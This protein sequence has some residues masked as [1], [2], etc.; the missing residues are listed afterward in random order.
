[1]IKTYKITYQENNKKKSLLINTENIKNE[2]LPL[3]VLNIKEVSIKKSINFFSKKKQISNKDLNL[4]FY[5]LNIMVQ[6]NI[7][8][9]EALDILIKNRK[10]EVLK[11]FLLDMKN[12]F[13]NLKPIT[14]ALEKYEVD[15]IVFSFL[16][17]CQSRGNIKLNIKAL[18]ILLHENARIKNDFKKAIRYPITLLISFFLSLN[19]IFYFVIP[20]F[21]SIFS[22][23]I[24]A[25][26]LSTKVLFFVHDVYS[27]Y[28][29]YILI[30]LVI[31]S[32]SL[33]I[34][35]KNNEKMQ[36]YFD[37]FIVKKL[38]LFKDIYLSSQSYKLFLILDIMHKS[39]Y[40]FHKALISSKV[41]LKNKY[42]LD[43][44]TLIENLLENG[45]TINYSFSEALIFDD[46]VL[47]L[48]NTAEVSN[49]LDITL[50]EIKEIYKNRF[51]EKIKFLISIIE[52]IF[53]VLLMG[54]IL[55]IVL[56]IFVPIWDM[57]N[58]IKS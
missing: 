44:I 23:N 56:A 27:N 38:Y 28:I 35:Y 50:V 34:Y 1:M 53:I 31:L 36:Y 10:S 49:S 9:T 48:I 52:P 45:K 46:L 55:W 2:N 20:N 15:E 30:L 18:S 58:M 26:P 21:K 41:L 6:S 25:L 17:L 39:N 32:I 42:L 13:T 43:R 8:F 37:E 33:Y 51:E 57:G 3:N 7:V 54:L 29:L 19:M 40:E 14:K 11:E 16:E 4:L 12:S 24:D 47:N 5:E 22:G